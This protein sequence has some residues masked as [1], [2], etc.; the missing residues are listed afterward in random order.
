MEVQ[1][2][3]DDV[4]KEYGNL[5][6]QLAL[7]QT[8]N[9]ADADDIF[10]EVFLR[11]VRAN[12]GFESEE[13][14]KA[15]LIRVTINCSRSLWHSAWRRKVVPIDDE[16][17]AEENDEST[18][19]YGQVLRLPP[20]YRTIIHLYYYEDMSIESISRSLNIGY[21][22][23]AKRLSRARELLRQQLTGGNDYEELSNQLPYRRESAQNPR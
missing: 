12:R 18:E 8:K 20:K 17:P 16:L 1:F 10:Q 21:S 23:A 15:W 11:L 9:S 13:H 14:L 19:L 3:P 4:L 22:A 6:Y 2:N 7:T 5:V